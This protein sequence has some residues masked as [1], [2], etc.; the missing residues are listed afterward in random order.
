[1]LVSAY[2]IGDSEV[3]HGLCDRVFQ[4]AES[5]LK[6]TALVAVPT[7]YD[8]V[9]AITATVQTVTQNLADAVEDGVTITNPHHM[10][11]L[12]QTMYSL[13]YLVGAPWS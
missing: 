6:V 5:W 1:M 4:S 7:V 11:E 13:P 12:R 8:D 9:E 3:R 10:R 2:R